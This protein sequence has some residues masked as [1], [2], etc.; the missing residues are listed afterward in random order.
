MH[1][2]GRKLRFSGYCV[3]KMTVMVQAALNGRRKPIGHFETRGIVVALL[4]LA[5]DDHSKGL[6]IKN[7]FR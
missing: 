5:S 4:Y 7:D 6:S 3:T 2:L 1:S